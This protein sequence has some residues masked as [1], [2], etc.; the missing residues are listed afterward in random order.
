MEEVED[1]TPALPTIAPDR[2]TAQ[3]Y[4]AVGLSLKAHPLSFVREHLRAQGVTPCCGLQD[5]ARTPHGENVSV[6]GLVLV[7][8]RP[9]TASGVVF[10]TLEDETGIANLI[11]WAKTF[12]KYRKVARLSTSLIAHG[13]VQREGEVVHVH[14]SRLSTVDGMLPKVR[15]RSRDFH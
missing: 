15:S 6:A 8:Q 11:L 13:R 4:G 10:I 12:E 14:V 5:A 9:G 7:R 1:S 3:D 2:Q